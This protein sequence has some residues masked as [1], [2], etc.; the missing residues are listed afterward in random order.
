M[1]N[2]KTIQRFL[3]EGGYYDGAIDGALGPKTFWGMT[4]CLCE[5][6]NDSRIS[7]QWN[8]DRLYIGI[9]QLMFV[10]VGIGTVGPID[11][12]KGPKFER[13]FEAWQDLQR[14]DPQWTDDALLPKHW[15]LQADVE[16]VFG[17]PG[18][19]LIWVKLPYPMR[20]AWNLEQVVTKVELHRLVAASAVS[21]LEEL[22]KYYTARDWETLGLNLHGGTFNVRPMKGNST[23]LSMHSYGIA[24]DWDP[25][26]NS[27]RMT[28]QQA[29]LAKPEYDAFWACWEKE[30]WISLGRARDFDWMH[31]QA[32]R[33]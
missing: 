28:R 31:V 29:R 26:H 2:T 33:L 15:P 32:A 16:K 17:A 10:I 1:I 8:D 21:V 25:D 22:R 11:G 20:L 7:Q 4:V 27:Y 19:D 13:A 3:R 30:G 12:Y 18:S 9:Q 5:K 23:K 24:W 14:H 6:L